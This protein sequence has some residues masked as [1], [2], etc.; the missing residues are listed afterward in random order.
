MI[1]LI[2]AQRLGSESSHASH[3]DIVTEI[4]DFRDRQILLRLSP[5]AVGKASG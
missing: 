3:C 1:V 5:W 2:D 4:S